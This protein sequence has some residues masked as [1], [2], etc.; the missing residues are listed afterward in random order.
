MGF[1]RRIFKAIT[2]LCVV[3]HMLMGREQGQV[4]GVVFLFKY[5]SSPVNASNTASTGT[6]ETDLGEEIFFAQ[7][8]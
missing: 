3:S 5:G 4:Y 7:Q 8:V 1:G 2:V 6:V